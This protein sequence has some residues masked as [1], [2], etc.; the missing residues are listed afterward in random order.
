MLIHSVTVFT[1]FFAIIN[2]LVNVPIF[3][4]LGS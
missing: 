4:G 2:P 1:G 3:I